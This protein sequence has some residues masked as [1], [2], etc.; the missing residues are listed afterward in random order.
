M[1]GIKITIANRQSTLVLDRRRLA[2][3]VRSVLRSA[4][5]QATVSVAVVD[6]P[7]MHE[8]NRRFLS[9]FSAEV[10]RPA[11]PEPAEPT[12]TRTGMVDWRSRRREIVAD[13]RMV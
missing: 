6:D 4:G 10:I 11:F 9:S 2:E 3:A 7:A 1:H 8:L 12:T 5:L 13:T